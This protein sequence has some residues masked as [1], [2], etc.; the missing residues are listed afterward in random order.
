MS[1]VLSLTDLAPV[2]VALIGAA[3]VVTVLVIAYIL[4]G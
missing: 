2:E 1:A 3:V 4:S